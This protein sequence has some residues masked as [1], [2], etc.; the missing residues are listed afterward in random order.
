MSRILQ[1]FSDP[2]LQWIRQRLRERVI[3]G[4]GFE[5]SIT[6]QNP[7]SGQTK[8]FEN[9]LGRSSRSRK[10]LSLKLASLEAVLKEAELAEDLEQAV[11]LLEGKLQNRREQKEYIRTQWNRLF[12]DAQ[13]EAEGE[14][15]QSDWLTHLRASGLLKRLSNSDITRAQLLLRQ[16]ITLLKRLNGMMAL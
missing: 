8:A 9:L 6:L 14:T 16:A 13:A 11:L 1:L 3:R 4:S 5:G 12:A 2:N 15:T 7:T 10:Q